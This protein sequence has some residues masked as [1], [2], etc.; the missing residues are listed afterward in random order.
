MRHDYDRMALLILSILLILS[1]VSCSGS[2]GK[3]HDALRLMNS[4]S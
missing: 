2:E 4:V 1:E 3:D